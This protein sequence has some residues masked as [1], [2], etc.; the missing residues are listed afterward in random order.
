MRID[1][2][3]LSALALLGALAAA[4][5][6]A[7]DTLAAPEA[8]PAAVQP[9]PAQGRIGFGGLTVPKGQVVEGDVVAPF[10]D[11]RVEGE[12]LGDVTVGKGNLTLA[13]GAVIH[14]DAVVT[15]GGKL[16]NE[17]GRVHGEMRVNSDE[18]DAAAPAGDGRPV[19]G[20]NLGLRHGPWWLGSFGEGAQGL[21][22]T[23]TFALILA[24]LGAALIF[25]ALPQLERVS[26]VVRTDT[27][28]AGGVGL[29]ANFLSIPAFIVGMVALAV[30]IIGIPLLI[31]YV[32]LFWVALMAAC[33]YGVVAV[34]HALGE[35]TAERSGS[36]A[37]GRRNA[38][39]YTFT[40][41][42]ILLAPLFVAHLLEL[43]V[44][45]GW[46]GDL[47]ELLGNLLLWVA[48]T[49]GFGAV[50]LTRAGTRPGW[51]WKPRSAYDPLFD[52]DPFAGPEPGGVHA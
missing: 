4:P 3:K 23:L 43:T 22:S 7:Q 27:L 36:Y 46:L 9:E 50:F 11:V 8:A 52:R 33:A 19:G 47:L 39:T 10:G 30:T 37:V 15:G 28:R 34:A 42:A 2:G 14:G 18:D 26:H 31:L 29:A 45:L 5:A 49:V 32:P 20:Q 48:A 17:G 21:V 1:I 41:I 13:P 6:A 35:R 51:P 25:Y 38:Y 24:G 12:V 40:G 16:F 44:F